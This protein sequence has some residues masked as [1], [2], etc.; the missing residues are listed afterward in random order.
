MGQWRYGSSY[1]SSQQ[2]IYMAGID[3]GRKEG[4][5]QEC[6]DSQITAEKEQ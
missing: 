6:S 4:R 2:V 5:R 1:S 3:G